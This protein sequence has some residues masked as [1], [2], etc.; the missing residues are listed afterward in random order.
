MPRHWTSMR[1]ILRCM[2]V[3][4]AN[5][6]A[7]EERYAVAGSLGSGG[8]GMVYRAFDRRLRRDV[9]LKTLR[10]ASGRD[11]YRFKRE[12]RSLADIVHPNLIAL[13]ELHTTGEQ[14]FFTM[15]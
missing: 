11:L 4:A 7:G 14:W 10:Q 15:E 13:H 5:S 8:M 12:F 6:I 1:A 3:P 2:A 9:A